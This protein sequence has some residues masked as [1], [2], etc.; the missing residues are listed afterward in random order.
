MNKRFFLL[1][2]L[3]FTILQGTLLPPVLIEGFLLVTLINIR[4]NDTQIGAK[5]LVA[6]FFGGLIF[7]LVQDK[8]LGSTPLIFGAGGLI[9]HFLGKSGFKN[10]IFWAVGAYIVLLVR[11]YF[12]WGTLFWFPAA[13]GAILTFLYFKFLWRETFSG[14]LM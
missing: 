9:L 5:T 11:G 3:I 4:E 1:L 12:L 2:S 6:L 14:K 13:I 8:T 10:L 7:D